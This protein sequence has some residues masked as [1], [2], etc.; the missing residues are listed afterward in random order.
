MRDKLRQLLQTE[1]FY[2]EPYPLNP[3]PLGM[4]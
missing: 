4:L 3:D 2:P 1:V